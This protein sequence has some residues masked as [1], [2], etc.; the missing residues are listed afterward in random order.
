VEVVEVV[1]G[2]LVAV[3]GEMVVVGGGDGRA[4]LLLVVGVV[5]TSASLSRW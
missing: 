1:D 5:A 3:D 4:L 2:R